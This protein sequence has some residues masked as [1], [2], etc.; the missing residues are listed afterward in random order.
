MRRIVLV[1]DHPL[2]NEG[3]RRLLN[4]TGQ[5]EV[6]ADFKDGTSF[7]D[8]FEKLHPDVVILDVQLPD[9]DG[10][11]LTRRVRSMDKKVKILMLSM[12]DEAVFRIEAQRAGANGFLSK[13]EDLSKLFEFIADLQETPT[14]FV[15]S[16]ER[17]AATNRI[18]L[19]QQEMAVLKRVAEG[20]TTTDIGRLLGISPLTVKTHRKNIFRKL[21]ASNSA[22]LIRIAYQR[23]IL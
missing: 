13:S 10:I 11:Q 5:Y 14:Q 8:A 7:L 16:H 15:E 22:E 3:V 17:K 20:L 21:N 19:S 6:V 2:I 18:H 4:S 1:D 23:G 12:H 9:I